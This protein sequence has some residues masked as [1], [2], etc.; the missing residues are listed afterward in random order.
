MIVLKLRHAM[1]AYRLRTGERLTY[2]KLAAVS[3]VPLGT[4]QSIASR[5]NYHP[6]L[7]NVDR[8]CLALD[9]PIQ[10][11][12]EVVPNPPKPRRMGKNKS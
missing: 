9:I 11:L 3:G 7:A 10:D 8:L 2:R 1:E 6:T 5:P 12:V 4:L